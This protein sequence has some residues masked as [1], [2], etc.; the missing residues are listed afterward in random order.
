MRAPGTLSKLYVRLTANTT[1]TNGSVTIR[2]NGVDT[3]LTVVVTAGSGA[4]VI[5]DTSNSVTVAAGDKLC[6][7]T[8]SGGTGTFT[9]SI[10]SCIFDATTNCSTRYVT[11]GYG[12]A[13]ASAS[14]FISIAGSRSG[15]NS[16]EANA[17]NTIKTAGTVKNAFINVTANART[18]N[19]TFTL[20]KNRV[21]TAIVFTY[22][23]GATGIQE[24]TG[25]SVSFAADDELDWEVTT[26][27]GTQTL[28]FQCLAVD[29]ETTTDN[30]VLSTGVTGSTSD[31]VQTTNVTW[32]YS[33]G[34]GMI[35][36]LTTEASAQ[37]KAREAFTFKNL[38]VFVGN[39]GLAAS[40]TFAFRVNG[41][42]VI[43]ISLTA[44]ATG[45][46]AN[47]ANTVTV[48]QAIL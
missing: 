17:E 47:T 9:F 40:A 46:F 15:T 5:E 28:T 45:F 48:R 27:T 25:T 30:G 19:T 41:A 23:S 1:S 33:I 7:E 35:Q 4:A 21:D 32:Y 44:V 24:V 36:G 29:Y 13:T 6:I 16:G 39:N 2:K 43:S 11:E 18:N 42:D 8:V 37:Q 38:V 12:V 34:G 26:L 3:A 22:G 10:I 14:H 20:R 31:I